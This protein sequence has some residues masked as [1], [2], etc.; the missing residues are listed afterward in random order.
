[1][2]DS[3]HFLGRRVRAIVV[4]DAAVPMQ[5]PTAR[6]SGKHR[7]PMTMTFVTDGTCGCRR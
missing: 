5:N 4:S 7:T 3:T 2:F 1:M 6:S